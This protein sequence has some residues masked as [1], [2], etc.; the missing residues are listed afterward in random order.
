MSDVHNQLA[1]HPLVTVPRRNSR[2]TTPFSYRTPA[3]IGSN[4]QDIPKDEQ[5]LYE[6]MSCRDAQP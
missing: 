6:S 5:E 4:R 2:G 1:Q 3:V